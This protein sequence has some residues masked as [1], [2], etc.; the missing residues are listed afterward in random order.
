VSPE[1]PRILVVE[2]EPDLRVLLD[3]HLD[4]AGYRVSVAEDGIEALERA[5]AEPVDL[6]L[7]DLMLPHLDGIEVCRRLRHD[8]R[9]ARLPIIM[10]TAKNETADRIRGFEVGAD[11]YINKPFNLQELVLRVAAVLRRRA[12]VDDFPSTIMRF[13]ELRLDP[14]SRIVTLDEVEVD[15]TAREFDLLFFLMNHPNRVF[16]RADLLRHVWEYDYTG[17][18]RTVDAHVARLR[19]KLGRS[20]EW[21]ETEWGIG[22]KFRPPSG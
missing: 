13:D 6:V 8:E 3:R 5:W 2:D 18:D 9:T 22:Y 10:L 17:Y 11:D 21:I 15:L 19:R 20:G 1:H 16:S 12:D 4:R 7:L 14:H